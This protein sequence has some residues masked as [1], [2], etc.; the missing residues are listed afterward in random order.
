MNN[1]EERKFD[2]GSGHLGNGISVYNKAK[3]VRGDYEKIAHIDANRKITWMLKNP[4]KEV[5]DYVNKIAS[6]K[7]PSVSTS[8]KDKKVFKESFIESK[9]SASEWLKEGSSVKYQ[10]KDYPTK[11]VHISTISAGDTVLHNGELHT[12]SRND[13]NSGGFMGT[14]LFGDS[15]S[16]GRR[17]VVKVLI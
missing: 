9:M 10:G 1:L 16:L 15:Y 6:G 12:V 3:D 14:T 11:E 4:P 5:T 8:Q 7:N 2:L 17:S 13:I